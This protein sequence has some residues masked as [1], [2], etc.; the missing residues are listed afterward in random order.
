MTRSADD[1]YD[2]PRPECPGCGQVIVTGQDHGFNCEYSGED[3]MK[4]IERQEEAAREQDFEQRRAERMEER[5]EAGHA[6]ADRAE[7][8]G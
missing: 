2:E 8:D 7:G 1:P 5:W 6:A 3:N 4:M